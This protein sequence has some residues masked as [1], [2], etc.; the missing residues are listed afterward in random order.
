MPFNP[1][2][3]PREVCGCYEDKVNGKLLATRIHTPCRTPDACDNMRYW[4]GGQLDMT[5]FDD[6]TVL[7]HVPIDEKV[8]LTAETQSLAGKTPMLAF[9]G[10]AK[11]NA[12]SEDLRNLGVHVHPF[13]L[14]HKNHGGDWGF[15]IGDTMMDDVPTN[16][17]MTC[18]HSNVL[19]FQI[20]SQ[21]TMFPPDSRLHELVAQCYGDGHKALKSVIFKSH[22]AHHDQPSTLC[23]TYPKAAQP[24]S[25]G[26]QDDLR[27]LSSSAL[28]GARPFKNP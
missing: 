24:C 25:S 5:I 23:T 27:R 19:I 7:F 11:H 15:S 14:F 3:L 17:R 13:C 2:S 21:S 20:L 12:F 16:M 4:S 22:P 9:V 8:M 28:Y 18:L 1:A 26:T 6:G 10:R